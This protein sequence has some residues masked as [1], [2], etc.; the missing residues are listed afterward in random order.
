MQTA[1]LLVAWLHALML[2]TLPPERIV[3][4]ISIEARKETVAERSAR[5]ESIASDVIAVV[6]DPAEAPLFAG[7]DGRAK[8]AATVLGLTR[9][10]SDWHLDVDNGVTRGDHKRSWCIGQV[11]LDADGVAKTP[12]GWTGPDLVADRKKCVRVVLRMARESFRACRALPVEERL[13]LYARGSCD[14]VEGQ[15][16]SRTRMRL[17]LAL[18]AHRAPP[19]LEATALAW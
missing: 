8:T 15:K 6:F 19:K 14:S 10:E 2:W 4:F 18:F 1:T 3:P 11:L 5:Y 16:L 9:Y 13:A 7:D 17:A 12:E